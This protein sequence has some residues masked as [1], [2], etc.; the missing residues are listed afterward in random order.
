MNEPNLSDPSTIM[1]V[2]NQLASYSGR[3]DA[4]R[5]AKERAGRPDDQHKGS[6]GSP[7]GRSVNPPSQSAA[8]G[9]PKGGAA[10]PARSNG[11]PR[12]SSPKRRLKATRFGAQEDDEEFVY[13]PG[14]RKPTASELRE[15]FVEQ[16]DFAAVYEALL[17]ARPSDN[18]D[19]PEAFRQLLRA[20]DAASRQNPAECSAQIFRVLLNVA[21]YCALR[22]QLNLVQQLEI[23]DRPDHLANVLPVIR[24][25]FQQ[26]LVPMHAHVAEL[27]QAQ[28]ATAR[29]WELAC[30]DRPKPQNGDRKS[31]NNA[32]PSQSNGASGRPVC[33]DSERRPTATNGQQPNQR[34]AESKIVGAPKAKEQ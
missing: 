1:T 20:I 6:N 12:R 25:E 9:R 30:R 2:L 7:D 24:E 3:P 15:P 11:S 22:V 19:F 16:G 29:L 8:S 4:V 5:V 33:T 32:L 27:C 31:G 26:Y 23:R 17:R 13:I 10:S 28:A 21:V 34:A 18:P 14:P